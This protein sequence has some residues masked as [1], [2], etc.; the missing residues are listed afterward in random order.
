MSKYVLIH[1]Q[2]FCKQFLQKGKW[3]SHTGKTTGITNKLL[4]KEEELSTR[5]SKQL[6]KIVFTA[7][8]FTWSSALKGRHTLGD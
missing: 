4:Y 5:W 2:G 1:E 7:S 8:Q 3:F 6:G